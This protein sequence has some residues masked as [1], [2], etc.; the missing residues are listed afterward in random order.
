MTNAA[1]QGRLGAGRGWIGPGALLFALAGLALVLGA[2]AAHAQQATRRGRVERILGDRVRVNLGTDDGVDVGAK[3]RIERAGRLV[4]RARVV[5]AGKERCQARVVEQRVRVAVGDD[6]LLLPGGSIAG[7]AARTAG[8]RAGAGA[9]TAGPRA[10][11][12]AQA[13]PVSPAATAAPGQ[14]GAPLSPEEVL[15]RLQGAPRA[16][17]PAP[18]PDVVSAKGAGA[19]SPTASASSARPPQAATS[20]PASSTRG[21]GST[22]TAAA[23]PPSKPEANIVTG[24]VRLSYDLNYDGSGDSRDLTTHSPRLGLNLQIEKVAGT[25]VA[26]RFGGDVRWVLGDLADRSG[27]D[28]AGQTNVYE[29]ALSWEPDAAPI[30]L[31]VGRVVLYDVATIGSIDGAR[32]G[33]RLGPVEVGAFGGL[34][35]RPNLDDRGRKKAGG[36]IRFETPGGE[37]FAFDL[38]LGYARAWTSDGEV[39]R[40]LVAADTRLR[41]APWAFV[42]GRVELDLYQNTLNLLNRS[43]MELTDAYGYLSLRP[44]ADLDLGL[45]VDYRLPF[46]GSEGLRDLSGDARDV[47]SFDRMT[48]IRLDARYR[49]PDAWWVA[50]A[51][52]LRLGGTEL[53]TVSAELGWESVLGSDVWMRAGGRVWDGDLVRGMAGRLSGGVSLGSSVDVELSYELTRE[54]YPASSDEAVRHLIEGSVFWYLGRSLSASASAGYETGDDAERAYGHLDLVYRF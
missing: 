24:S 5:E 27:S 52:D 6:V 11:T 38:A 16:V 31:E 22:A 54:E 41:I 20:E 17:R 7:A 44:L 15:R 3:L 8:P 42:L 25:N 34:D 21:A 33:V 48:S 10:G 49:L 47:I 12:G 51:I 32:L 37:R 40:D 45:S 29:A 14:K 35:P 36:Y 26:F 19:H 30:R 4:A 46:I 23:R 18:R 53:K 28:L 39:D 9:R 1:S 50:G 43:G 2:R 13:A